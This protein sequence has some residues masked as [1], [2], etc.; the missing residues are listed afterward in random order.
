MSPVMVWDNLPDGAWPCPNACGGLTDDEGGGPCQACWDKVTRPRDDDQD[1]HGE[2]DD[3][4]DYCGDCGGFRSLPLTDPLVCTCETGEDRDDPY[5]FEPA[6]VRP[7]ER[8][9]GETTIHL[10]GDAP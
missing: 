6:A 1:G 9:R 4:D 7:G 3:D 8:P 5:D 2:P 10:P